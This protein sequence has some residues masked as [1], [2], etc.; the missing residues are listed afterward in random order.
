MQ[1]EIAKLTEQFANMEGILE[2][3]NI[4]LATLERRMN[5]MLGIMITMWVTIIA[6]IFFKP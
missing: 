5:L 2:Q 1:G 6:A 3:M 4:R